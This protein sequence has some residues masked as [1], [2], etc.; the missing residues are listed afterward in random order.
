MELEL[1]RSRLTGKVLLPGEHG[2]DEAVTGFNLA[3]RREPLAV[4]E[5]ANAHD[6]AT[7][8]RFAAG[9]GLK[10]AVQATGH[11]GAPVPG[12]FIQLNTSRLD[13]CAVHAE[14]NYGWARVGAGVRW[15]RVLE[16]A[17][18]HG[19]APLAGSAPH[20]G[21]VGY[22]T[23]GGYGPIVR[24]H[25]LAS[26]L[27][28]A[29]EVV[30]GDG[31]FRRVTA[32]E[33]PELFWGLRG[34]KGALGI[35]TAVEFDL[36]PIAEI[37]GGSVYFDGAAAERVLRRWRDWSDAL[38]AQGTTSIAL[39]RLPD[40]PMLPPQLAGRLTVCVRF[41]WVGDPAEGVRAFAPMRAA[42]PVILGEVGPM[43]YAALGAIH[44]DPDQPMP[45]M[46]RN[47]L[48][49]R[50]LPDD[51]LDT[52]L[53]WAGPEST[54]PQAIIELRQLGGAIGLNEVPSAVSHRNATHSLFISSLDAPQIGELCRA[55]ADEML[56][57]LAPWL[58]D[59][60]LPN[61]QMLAT[62][63]LTAR[64]YER[65]T[66]ARLAALVARFD[67]RGVLSDGRR[68]TEAAQL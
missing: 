56:A 29:F 59:G 6:V 35:V 53:A 34:G 5:A 2:Y 18:P 64:A 26:D 19:L 40:L 65:N 41:A 7:T 9:A 1:L 55:H 47:A 11:G 31:E 62:P 16:A 28:R 12:D 22:L 46:D 4:V 60:I 57:A 58:G 51:A 38:P 67:P 48:F 39:K 21:V 52:L 20:V 44:Q 23:G 10:V 15:E 66:L 30:T 24:S 50:G 68:L 3:L 17:A 13:E 42:A 45:V 61:F 8:V 63:Q 49:T 36:L 32:A 37:A 25:G 54:S 33:E 27:V 14:Q 43:P